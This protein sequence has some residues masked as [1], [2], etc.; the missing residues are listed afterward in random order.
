MKKKILW[1][2]A[3]AAVTLMSLPASAQISKAKTSLTTMTTDLSGLFDT[4]SKVIYAIAA[5][6]GLIGGVVVY[7]KWSS[8]DPNTTK[9]VGAWFGS[10]LFLAVVATFLRAMFL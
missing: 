6:I 4:A 10:A 8:G 9:L 1:L 7:Q 5:L 2:A 3:M